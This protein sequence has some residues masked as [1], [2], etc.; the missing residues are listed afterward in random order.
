[1][2]EKEIAKRRIKELTEQLREHNYRYYVLNQPVI[3]DVEFDMLMKELEALEQKYPEFADP[4][5]PTKRVG[6]DITKKFPVVRHK[7]PMLSLAN[8]YSEQEVIDF[9]KRIKKWLEGEKVEYTCELKYDGVAISIHYLNGEFHQAVTRGDGI[10]GE[11][12]SNNVK[13]IKAIPLKLRGNDY[14]EDLEI[15]GEIFLPYDEFEKINEE[16][17]KNGEPPF[18]NPRNT[19]AGTLKL[20]DSSIVAKR[21]LDFF[22]YMV[23]AEEL[24]Q[25]THYDSLLKAREWGIKVPPPEKKFLQKCRN[26]DEIM[27]FIQYWDIERSKLPFA[28]DGTVIKVNSFEQQQRLGNTAKSPRWAIAYKFQAERAVTILQSVD[29]Q[30]GRTGAITPVANLKPVLL[31]GTV[32]KRASLHNADQIEKLDL[33]YG[34]TVFVEKGGEIIPKI[35]GVDVKNRPANA[36]KVK[37]IE[38]CPACGSKLVR[39]EGDARHYCPN[40]KHCPPQIIGRLQHFISRKAMDIEGI[41]DETVVQLYEKLHITSPHQLYHLTYEDFLKLEG[42]AD[43]SAKN[44]VVGIEKSKKVPFERVLYALGI[45]HV[46]ETVAKILAKHFKSID[47]LMHASQEELEAVPDIGPVI[48]RA[49]KEFFED[50]DNIR[51]I[52]DLKNSG[53]QFEI[54]EEEQPALKSE[55]LKGLT[56]VVSG[57]F[58]KHSRE[59]IKKIIEE[60]GGKVG[61]SVSGKTNYIVAGENMGPSKYEKALKLGIPIISEDDLMAMIEEK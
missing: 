51:M 20:Q 1:M 2:T 36:P 45:I 54:Q 14:P 19:A 38:N 30:V 58:K 7:V 11:D 9:E 8:T 42:F 56:I 17:Q 22:C 24:R 60:N 47:N 31:S 3:S 33:H 57:V 29:F 34:D 59:E 28:I 4:N 27:D 43:K 53:L 15:R 25:T 32:V 50:P 44:A 5:S 41:G 37:F 21:N 49:V 12:I 52:E 18:A 13:T 39:Y 40:H 10:Q 48:A 23:I 6:G 16:R 35:V 26:I 46:G 55:K 61:S